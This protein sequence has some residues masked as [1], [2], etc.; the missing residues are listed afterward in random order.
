[1]WYVYV[2][3]I[4][5]FYLNEQMIFFLLIFMHFLVSELSAKHLEYMY[6]NNLIFY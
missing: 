2:F 4:F 3:N 6:D 5:F 1:M